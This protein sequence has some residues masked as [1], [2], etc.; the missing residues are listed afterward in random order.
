MF[1]LR[2]ERTKRRQNGVDFLTLLTV[3][4]GH[5]VLTLE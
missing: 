1:L 5:V 2:D 4:N 3:A